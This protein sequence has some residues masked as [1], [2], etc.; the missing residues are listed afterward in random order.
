MALLAFCASTCTALV[1]P[2]RR[3]ASTR[4][5]ATPAP[6][7]TQRILESLG[8]EGDGAGAGAAGSWQG[9]LAAD[10]AWA[11]IKSGSRPLPKPFVSPVS[12]SAPAAADYD[13]VVLGGTLGIFV[14]AALARRGLK[15]AVIERGALVG[16]NQ[17]WNLSLDE[18]N[19]LVAAGAFDA[20]DVDG[21]TG[22]PGRGE[23]LNGAAGTLVAS[24]FGSVRAGFNSGE[25]G[26]TGTK[27]VQEVWLPGVLN[28]GVRPAVAV[29]R[30]RDVFER[31]GGVVLERTNSEGVD[32][33]DDCAVVRAVSADGA[34]LAVSARLVID[35][36]GNGSPLARQTRIENNGGV[37]PRPSGV[38]CVVGTLARGYAKDNSFGDLIYTNEPSTEDRQYFWEAFPSSAAADARTTYLFTYLD[39]DS[40]RNHTVQ[41]Q[42]EDY[43]ERLPKYQ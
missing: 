23:V 24:H 3:A 2:R 4:L 30:A 40:A 33:Y 27:G 31:F 15:V 11:S 18:V 10:R 19:A 7:R 22:T 39:A 38:C 34:P 43:W 16:R 26:A 29:Q 13:A 28:V 35:A 42:F 6:S 41:G 37:E 17:E 5:C 1:A 36:M 14:A 21:A 12:G 32:V 8:A 9:V 25:F 20:A